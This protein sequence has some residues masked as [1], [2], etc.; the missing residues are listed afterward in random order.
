MSDLT[1]VTVIVQAEEGSDQEGLQFRGWEQNPQEPEKWRWL[2]KVILE[3]GIQCNP[4][5]EI[6]A[7]TAA[8]ET[9]IW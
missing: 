3:K 2:P 5:W 7:P 8:K 6:P 1:W 9:F 4:Q